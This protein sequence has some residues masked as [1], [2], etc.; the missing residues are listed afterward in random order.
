MSAK[1]FIKY[2]H[3]RRMRGFSLLT[4]GPN[5]ARFF[6]D[7]LTG[8]AAL[9]MTILFNLF[10][11]K[12]AFGVELFLLP[13]LLLGFNAAAGIYSYL[14]K[15][16][17]KKKAA[18][19]LGTLLAIC[20]TALLIGLPPSLVTLW[21]FI[22]AGPLILPRIFLGLPYGRH[23]SIIKYVSNE[24]GPVLVVGGAGYI[25]SHVV[26]LLLKEG[27]SV[28]VLDRLMYGRDSISDF[29]NHR[30]FELIE[31]DATDIAQLTRAMKDVS[32]VVHLAGLVG[33]PACAID[34][35]FTRHTNVVSTRM[36]KD[37]AQSMGIYRFI[38][39][40]SC[41]VYGVSEKEVKESDTLN[42]VS[43]Y[44]QT[45]IDS[46]QE[47][48]YS[49]RDDFFV[50]I[51]RFATVFGH[52]RRPRFD[53]VGNLFTAQG[54]TDGLIRVIGPNQ[55]RP[56]IH[57]RDL[58]RAVVMTLKADPALMQG[59]IFNVGDKRLNMTIGQLGEGVTALVAKRK[60]VKMTLEENI[61]DQRNY[62]VSFE[63]IRNT[64]GFEASVLLD[65]GIEEMIDHFVN[66]AYENY[67]DEIYSNLAM[68]KK[69]LDLFHDPQQTAGLYAPIGE[70]LI[71]K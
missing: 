25:G 2:I 62:A 19:L 58:A 54:M 5:E 68:T 10:F 14:K 12:V 69:A 48:L 26:D 39:A 32:A 53:L 51:L 21:G 49:V 57:V 52:S 15:Q 8:W 27:K 61:Q 70:R 38:F 71:L 28:R 60:A 43:I 22:T 11:I 31:G 67:K 33:D 41:S 17:G 3:L 42:P 50:T 64:L 18:I 30:F 46:E 35:D 56:F 6:Y 44:A 65:E 45:K 4:L 7:F 40:S 13:F 34:P 55:W 59:Q 63:K 66:G 37:V 1:K 24:K 23:K 47:L 29:L 20:G 36:T 16:V 9:L